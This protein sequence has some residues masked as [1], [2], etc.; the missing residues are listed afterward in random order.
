MKLLA[1]TP[2]TRHLIIAWAAAFVLVLLLGYLRVVT[3]AEYAFASL[4]LVPV[5]FVSWAGGIRHGIWVSLLGALLW[6]H[7][8]LLVI[9]DFSSVWIPYVNLLVRLASYLFV[10]W[11]TAKVALMLAHQVEQATHDFLTGLLNRRAFIEA[12]EAEAR[13]MARYGGACAVIYLDLDAFKTLNDTR[14]HECGD[15]ALQSLS[16]ALREEI[17]E[18]DLAAR[19][20][21]DEFAVLL[22]EIDEAGVAE[23]AEKIAQRLRSALADFPPVSASIGVAWFGPGDWEFA[24][25]LRLADNLMYEVKKTGKGALKQKSFVAPPNIKA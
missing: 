23:G 13:R 15:A 8:D 1:K 14:G 5:F 3:H 7:G 22:P 12:G 18:T 6:L 17:R 19:L 16:R 9:E 4:V 2:Q 25:M 20:G 24:D 21:G 10:A 11:L